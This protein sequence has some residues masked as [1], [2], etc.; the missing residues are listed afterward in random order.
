MSARTLHW[1]EWDFSGVPKA[2]WGVCL[3]YELSRESEAD[4]ARVEAAR[5]AR[6]TLCFDDQFDPEFML[7]YGSSL[8]ECAFWPEFPKKPFQKISALTRARRARDCAPRPWSIVREVMEQRNFEPH[9]DELAPEFWAHSNE[10]FSYIA[11]EISRNVTRSAFLKAC[12]ALWDRHHNPD[13]PVES[14]R[15]R[16]SD[17]ERLKWLGAWR[18]LRHTRGDMQKAAGIFLG[19]GQGPLYL[20]ERGWSKAVC[21]AEKL[22]KRGASPS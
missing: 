20:S 15:G 18:L 6:P 17:M 16:T 22:L 13:I 2:E 1:T 5:A 21:A 19:R 9:S 8:P 10:K 4:K 12:S 14:G 7:G 3:S 11:L